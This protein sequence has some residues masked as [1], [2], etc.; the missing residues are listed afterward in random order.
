[1]AGTIEHRW[2]G[3]TLTITSDSGT[4]SCDLKGAKG[5]TGIRGPQGI[6]GEPGS[7]GAMRTEMDAH[8]ADTAAHG[9]GA[10]AGDVAA[11]E[12]AVADIPKLYA[13]TA[14]VSD[15]CAPV[16][17][18]S[19]KENPHG[20]TAAQVGA[21]PVD[22]MP[23]AEQVGARPVDWM[24]TAA[25][26]GARPVDWLPTA[27]DIGAR[28]VEWMPTAA[29]VGAR[30]VDWLPTATDEMNTTKNAWGIS[31]FQ[32]TFIN[33]PASGQ[34]AFRTDCSMLMIG[35][36][37]GSTSSLGVYVFSGYSEYR[38]PNIQEISVGQNMTV[39]SSGD[40]TNGWNVI[41]SNSNANSVLCLYFMGQAKPHV[42]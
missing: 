24:P 18:V 1:M 21:R 22:W 35:R 23:T 33:V 2:D 29:D 9:L 39:T 25:Q 26:V 20:V 5:D 15:T 42:I 12:Q 19:N 37:A 7:T 10:I 14:Y 28:P 11:L 6:Q 36:L 34:L 30:P 3:T 4:S 32:T 8:K 40:N 27:A 38:A 17:H 16:G 41:V 31:P 13:T